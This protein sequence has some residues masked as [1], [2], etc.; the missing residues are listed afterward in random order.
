[1]S[2]PFML[3]AQRRTPEEDLQ[4][5]VAT[6]L[7]AYLPDAVWWSASLSGVKL[8][9]GIAAKA[10]AAGM[11]RGAPDIS[12]VWPDG[13]TTYTEL[14]AG[15]GVLT[16]EQKTL[17][18]TLG[19]RFAVCRSWLEV[20]AAVSGWME[21]FGLRWLTERESLRRASTVTRAA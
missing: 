1:M 17:A 11:Q 15:R 8:S 4:R 9:P 16:P 21:P 19:S 14:K 5:Q 2:R 13:E 6:M 10:K 12:Y 20:K 7:R 3:R 18:A